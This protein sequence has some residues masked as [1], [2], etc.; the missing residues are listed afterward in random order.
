MRIEIVKQADG[1]GVLRCTR[2][3]GS[4]SWQKQN[5]HA[6]HFSLHDL[7]HYAVETTLGYRR[8]FFGLV[9]EG[10]DIDDTTGKGIRGPVPDEAREVEGIVGLFDSERGCGTLWNLEELNEH[11]PRKLTAGEAQEIRTRRARLFR[12]WFDVPAGSKLELEFP[13]T[14]SSMIRDSAPNLR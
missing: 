4:V 7:T 5:R 1:T 8:G 13:E 3:D 10:W 9:S 6:A 14:H 11:S 12:E 2:S